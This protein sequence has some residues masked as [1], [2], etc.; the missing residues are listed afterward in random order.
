M[1]S[2]LFN[3]PQSA[4][5]IPQRVGNIIPPFTGQRGPQRVARLRDGRTCN[6]HM[7]SSGTAPVSVGGHRGMNLACRATGD[8]CYEELQA[9]RKS[10]QTLLNAAVANE[11]YKLAAQFKQQLTELDQSDPVKLL[12]NAFEQAVKEERYK[13]AAVIQKKL[14]E[15][16][17]KLTGAASLDSL[18]NISE[19]VTRGIRVKVESMYIAAQSQPYL[20]QY[21]FA[22]R[23]TITN[24]G[25]DIVQ[26]RSRHWL[27]VNSTGRTEEVRGPG[28]VGEQPIL[29]PGKSFEYQSGCPLKTQE[30]YMEGEYQMVVLNDAGDWGEEFEAKIGRFKLSAVGVNSTS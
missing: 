11:D 24:E 16:E 30:G 12:R 4:V 13:D 15:V 19:E 1:V 26:L 17:T 18:S 22:Y 10:L 2:P 5:K 28:V 27:I 14:R 9:K 8:K 23:V 7:F 3:L 25:T 21:F 20:D 6:E 29:L